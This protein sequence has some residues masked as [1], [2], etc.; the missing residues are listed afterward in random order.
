MNRDE[1]AAA[2]RL[3]KAISWANTTEGH[4]AIEQ[5]NRDARS[6]A[7]LFLKAV[8]W[9]NTSTGHLAIERY[10]REVREAAEWFSRAVSWANT[11][12]GHL[13]I[14]EYNRDVR[15]AAE[16]F[17]GAVSWANTSDG[18]LATEEY[19]RQLRA[20]AERILGA[21][22]WVNNTDGHIAL[23]RYNRELRHAAQNLFNSYSDTHSLVANVASPKI[24]P[25]SQ[26]PEPQTQSS[27]DSKFDAIVFKEEL[28]KLQENI[29]AQSIQTSS[30]EKN[31]ETRI[32]HEIHN[33]NFV[34]LS[35][36]EVLRLPKGLIVPKTKTKEMQLYPTSEV[37]NEP[38]DGNIYYNK[39][40]R[41]VCIWLEDSEYPEYSSWEMIAGLA[42]AY[43]PN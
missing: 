35:K 40:T 43:C 4:L 16:W 17:S 2:E 3:S 18:H 15:A 39:K 26:Q 32:A 11:S 37:P 24:S 19:N 12:T 23:Q 28:E 13:A 42:G 8:S 41:A 34:K 1:R 22:S 7:D 10:N 14:E 38:S 9:A 30:I 36:D 6:A 5:M 27:T 31:I 21:I 33:E 20:A 29:S 25:T